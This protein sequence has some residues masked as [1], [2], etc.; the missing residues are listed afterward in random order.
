MTPWLTTDVALLREHYPTKGAPRTQAEHLP[1]RTLAAIRA[2]AAEQK[3]RTRHGSTTGKRFPRVH[4]P[5]DDIDMQ[6][7]EAYIHAT[8]RGFLH[9]LALRLGK[10]DWWVQKRAALLG[11]TRPM[12]VDVWTLRELDI[13]EQW[14]HAGL[15]VIRQNL[16]AAGFTRTEGAIGIQLKRRKIDRTD[17]DTWTATSVAPMLGVNPATVADW[18]ERRGLKAKRVTWGPNGKLIITRADLKRWVNTHRAHV[19]LRRVDQHWFMELM[20][21]PE[22]RVAQVGVAAA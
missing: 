13:L 9:R 21:G 22:P 15:V 1:H 6:I 14:A 3:V 4:P 12:R 17:P 19:D 2:K 18:C 10:P 16:R 11:V 7:R 20:L 5:R 8:E